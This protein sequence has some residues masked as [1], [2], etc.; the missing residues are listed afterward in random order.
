MYIEQHIA[1]ASCAILIILYVVIKP[2]FDRKME[3]KKRS[4][5]PKEEVDLSYDPMVV[6]EEISM[7]YPPYKI[8][9][10]PLWDN[11]EDFTPYRG[12]IEKKECE[13]CKGCECKKK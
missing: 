7:P 8:A 3:E 2:I 1:A 5:E 9:E 10:D 11:D 6:N 4:Q 13:V 12:K